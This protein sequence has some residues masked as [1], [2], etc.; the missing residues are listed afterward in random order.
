MQIQADVLGINCGAAKECGGYG[1][2]C[3]LSGW[4]CG[5]VLAGQGGHC[6]AVAGGSGF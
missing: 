5:G 2:G 6:A 1:A 3:G 4:D